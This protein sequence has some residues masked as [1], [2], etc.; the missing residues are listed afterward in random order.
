MMT[1][2]RFRYVD[3]I[4]RYAHAEGLELKDVINLALHEFFERRHYLLNKG[5][6][7]P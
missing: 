6:M 1:C 4:E 2:R 5:S 7:R 3:Q